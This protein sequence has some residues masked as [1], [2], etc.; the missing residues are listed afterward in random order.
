MAGR[1]E[2]VA[3]R[4]N[5]EPPGLYA[6]AREKPPR[7]ADQPEQPLDAEAPHPPRRRSLDSG[8]VVEGRADRQRHGGRQQVLI[9]V[10]PDLLP[11]HAHAD[12]QDVRLEFGDLLDDGGVLLRAGAHVE[13]AVAHRDFGPR[14]ARGQAAGGLFGHPRC[15]PEIEHSPVLARRHAPEVVAPVEVGATVKTAAVQAEDACEE[16]QGSGVHLDQIGALEE[17]GELRVLLGQ[18]D[19]VGVVV[20]DA[21]GRAAQHRLTDV[22]HHLFRADQIDVDTERSH[23][24]TRSP[25]PAKGRT[26]LATALCWRWR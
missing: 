17:R 20:G 22:V 7:V 23:S 25:R 13:E 21:A 5:D 15:A 26:A 10:D 16:D 12:E 19:A 4:W 3:E 8:L 6:V 1:D 11:R 24:L 14:V 2:D 9:A 18:I